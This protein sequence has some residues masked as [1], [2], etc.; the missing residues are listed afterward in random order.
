MNRKT[1]LNVFYGIPQET[2]YPLMKEAGFDG[3]FS[4]PEYAEDLHA[5]KELHEFTGELGLFQETVHST[6]T[7]PESIWFEGPE[8]DQYIDVLLNNVDH[9]IDIGVPILVVHPQ[10]NLK[11]G[12][13]IDVGLPRMKRLVDYAGERGVRI[14]FENVDSSELLQSVMEAF[15]EEHVGFCYDSGHE[16]WLTPDA[17]WLQ[18]YGER[19]FCLHLNDND[20]NGDRHW[21]PGD[22]IVDFEEIFKVLKAFEYQGPI[23]LEVAY[24]DCYL[25]RYDP[26]SFVEK[27][28]EITSEMAKW[29]E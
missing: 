23:T 28:K 17:H 27:C 1:C 10:S 22:G 4:P 16:C 29:L 14:A 9:C 8:G 13:R 11:E 3:F 21:L 20:G 7:V 15:P 24:R 18:K 26:G 5:L 6:L 25:D 19:L 12:V 2:L